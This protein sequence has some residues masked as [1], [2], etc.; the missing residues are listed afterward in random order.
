MEAIH[1]LAKLFQQAV[2]K[3]NNTPN[4]V[5]PPAIT[6]TRQAPQPHIQTALQKNDALPHR[7]NI[8]ED[9][10]GNQ[11]QKFTHKNPPLGLGPL[12]QRTPQ[13]IPPNYVTSPMVTPSPRAEESPRY[14]TRSRIRQQSSI[15]TK[16]A[17]AENYIAI[18]E[19]NSVTHPITGQSQEYRHLIRGDE[20]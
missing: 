8:I 6:Q 16:Y 19:A 12:P 14:Q 7:T 17:D 20:K 11:P 18:A 13:H 3:N 1:Q 9:N 2:T 15:S 4:S 5:A 10:N